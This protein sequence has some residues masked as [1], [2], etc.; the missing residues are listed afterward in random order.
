MIYKSYDL[1]F[2]DDLVRKD[3]LNPIHH[4]NIKALAIELLG[5]KNHLSNQ[6]TCNI[7]PN[8]NFLSTM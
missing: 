7:F 3:N 5:I 1:L 2:T 6:I 4:V 8:Q